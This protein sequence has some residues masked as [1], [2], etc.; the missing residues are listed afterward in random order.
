MGDHVHMYFLIAVLDTPP[1]DM[2]VF[3]E[4]VVEQMIMSPDP[5]NRFTH[6]G[7]IWQIT[8]CVDESICTA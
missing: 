6:S 8:I 3:G 4:E 2:S 5:Q 1:E 7:G